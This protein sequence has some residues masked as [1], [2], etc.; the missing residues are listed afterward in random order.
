MRRHDLRFHFS[1]RAIN[2]GVVTAANFK[3]A[4]TWY[5]QNVYRKPI[6]DIVIEKEIQRFSDWL[7]DCA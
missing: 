2:T 5:M 1:A 6:R 3:V 4:D 7:K